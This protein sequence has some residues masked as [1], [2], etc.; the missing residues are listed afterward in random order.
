M[1]RGQVVVYTGW[2]PIHVQTMHRLAGWYLTHWFP[3]YSTVG[4]AVTV[5]NPSLYKIFPPAPIQKTIALAKFADLLILL[6]VIFGR[7]RV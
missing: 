1:R 2:S 6:L 3:D 5:A 7:P 4:L